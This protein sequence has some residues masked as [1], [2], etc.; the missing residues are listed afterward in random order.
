MCVCLCVVYTGNS[1]LDK[2][3]PV[4]PVQDSSEPQPSTSSGSS[5]TYNQVI[6]LY[7]SVLTLLSIISPFREFLQNL[8]A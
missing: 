4:Q 2:P 7:S 8:C 5:G 1:E 6:Y 3:L